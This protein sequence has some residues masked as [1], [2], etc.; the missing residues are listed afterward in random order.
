M[1]KMISPEIRMFLE[2]LLTDKKITVQG[3]LREQM[4]SD[5][6]DRLEVRLNQVVI[7]HLSADQLEQMAKAAEEGQDAV[8]VFL[9]KHIKNL[10][11]IMA[12]ALNEFARIYLEG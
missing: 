10:D 5:L 8:R 4:I 7:E 6:N 2:K 12:E 1:E 11:K 9:R 3:P